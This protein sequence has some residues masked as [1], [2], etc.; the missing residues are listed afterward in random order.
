M[1]NHGETIHG[2]PGTDT[3]PVMK[4]LAEPPSAS[5]LAPS[6][7]SD[8]LSATRSLQCWLNSG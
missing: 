3:K 1:Y 2:I 6:R 4:S 5:K 8:I 7:A